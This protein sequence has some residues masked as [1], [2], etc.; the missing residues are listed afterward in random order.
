M[1][2]LSKYNR[3][4]FITAIITLLST[5]VIYYFIIHSIL[6]T[7]LD[8]DFKVE[9]Q[10]VFDYVKENKTLPN[11][12]NYKD[13]KVIFEKEKS[14]NFKRQIVSGTVYNAAEDEIEPTRILSFPITVNGILYKAKVIKSQVEAEDL[15]QVI[16]LA[17]AAVFLLLLIITSLINRFLLAK[18]WQPFYQTLWQLRSFHINSAKPLTLPETTVTEFSELNSSVSEM[19]KRVNYEYEALKAFTDN[20]SH[21]MQTPLAIINSKLD[22]LLQTSTEK[23]AEQLQAIYD[24]TGRLTKLNQTLLLL[25]KIS[26]EQYK[27]QAKVDLTRLLDNKFKQFDELIKARNIQLK[28]E[29]EQV[30]INI[31]EAL[32]EIMLNN[33]I[34][35]AIKHNYND[36]FLHCKLTAHKLVFCNSGAPLSFEKENIFRRFQ[37]G[38][39]SKGTGLGLAVAHEICE[40]SGMQISY[41]NNNHEHIITVSF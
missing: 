30:Y 36:G 1:K 31:N 22:L 8:K 11:P 37:K 16:V 10:E 28:Y 17:T 9:E 2:L 33:L 13:Q 27:Q 34:S 20:A 12:T 39:L 41:D 26:N 24:A 6:I 7:Q 14:L 5:S 3:A 32:I 35:N 25:T 4:N 29:R 40:N 21:E 15:L 23:Q 18:L 19:T 38:D